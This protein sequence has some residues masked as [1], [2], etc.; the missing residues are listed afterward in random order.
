MSTLAILYFA[1]I[2]VVEAD[3][4][5]ENLQEVGNN[6]EEGKKNFGFIVSGIMC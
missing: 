1:G 5:K 2:D 3:G 6:P 4:I